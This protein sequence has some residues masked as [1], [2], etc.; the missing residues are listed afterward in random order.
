[1]QDTEKVLPE[2][3]TTHKDGYKGISYEK[4]TPVLVEAIKELSVKN[5]RQ[6]KEIDA[7][8]H[9]LEAYQNAHP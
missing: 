6:A 3:V 8:R 1:V 4:L 2:I 5:D 7:L 9:D